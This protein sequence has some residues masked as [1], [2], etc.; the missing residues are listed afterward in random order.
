ML[1][2]LAKAI[3]LLQQQAMVVALVRLDS[4]VFSLQSLLR[5]RQQR[6][7]RRR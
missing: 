2:G 3:Q 5:F 7:C 1:W 4:R 6:L